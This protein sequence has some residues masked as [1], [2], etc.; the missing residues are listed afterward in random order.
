MRPSILPSLLMNWFGAAA[1]SAAM[2]ISP[3]CSRAPF[4][5]SSAEAGAIEK[6]VMKMA[7]DM[8]LIDTIVPL[9]WSPVTAGRAAPRVQEYRV[10]YQL[11][12]QWVRYACFRNQGLEADGFDHRPSLGDLQIL[13]LRDRLILTVFGQMTH[14]QISINIGFYCSLYSKSLLSNE[15]GLIG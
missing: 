14:C 3:A 6:M 15:V 7:E 4:G 11:A 5:R 1:K 10:I 2:A 8:D 9:F 13:A 12:C